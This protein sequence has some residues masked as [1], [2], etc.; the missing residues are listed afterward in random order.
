MKFEI[1]DLREEPSAL[2]WAIDSSRGGGVTLALA[3]YSS[4]ATGKDEG[5]AVAEAFASSLFGT[6]PFLEHLRDLKDDQVIPNTVSWLAHGLNFG[7]SMMP[8][9]LA[10][11]Y[12]RK[13]LSFF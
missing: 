13:F 12:V 10:A 2:A 1:L 3:T 6:D 11:D 9:D 7:E 8:E 4:H 5:I